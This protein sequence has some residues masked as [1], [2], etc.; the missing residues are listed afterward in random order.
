M[1]FDKTKVMAILNSRTFSGEPE[2]EPQKR[3]VDAW[4][5]DKSLKF[6]CR[7]L[8]GSR[9]IAWKGWPFAALL[10]LRWPL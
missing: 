4:Q 6:S 5:I 3:E 10:F 8:E 7:G 9:V 2:K 1:I